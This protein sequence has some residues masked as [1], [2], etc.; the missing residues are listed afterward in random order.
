MAVSLQKRNELAERMK[1]LGVLERDLEEAFV[2]G[3]GKGGQKVNKTNNCVCLVH[4]PTGLVIKC[5]REREREINR[6][7]ARRALCDELD[8]RL[9]GAPS[10]KQMEAI[11]ARKRG[12][13][14]KNISIVQR[15]RMVD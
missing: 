2:R 14:L 12:S 15:K 11:R 4:R 1:T 5:H 8:H 9:N 3:S 7:L 13:L 6:F 10:P